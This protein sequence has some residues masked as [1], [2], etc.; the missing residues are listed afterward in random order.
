MASCVRTV[1]DVPAG[2]ITAEEEP[3]GAAG[4]AGGGDCN[5][6]ADTGQGLQQHCQQPAGMSC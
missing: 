1:P 2:K 5:R 6:A 4:T 3:E